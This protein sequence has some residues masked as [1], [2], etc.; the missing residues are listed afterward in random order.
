MTLADRLIL[1]DMGRNR[2]S[3]S[4]WKY[5][6]SRQKEFTLLL[7]GVLHKE[8]TGIFFFRESFRSLN[9]YSSLIHP[10]DSRPLG[11]IIPYNTFLSRGGFTVLNSELLKCTET[12][13]SRVSTNRGPKDDVDEEVVQEGTTSPNPRFSREE[14]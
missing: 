13:V 11:P 9:D 10:R 6:E 8:S 2:P 1:S 12:V 3:E 4:S 14:S 7:L 5:F